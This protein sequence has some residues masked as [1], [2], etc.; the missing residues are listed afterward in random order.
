M[1][2]LAQHHSSKTISLTSLKK[3][4]EALLMGLKGRYWVGKNNL[5]IALKDLLKHHHS[6]FDNDQAEKVLNSLLNEAVRSN[7]ATYKCEAIA[8]YGLSS[9]YLNIDNFNEFWT[10]AAPFIKPV[11]CAYVLFENKVTLCFLRV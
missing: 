4:V 10:V 8:C 5:V 2:S 3:L 9:V 7:K 6:D 11:S 1:S